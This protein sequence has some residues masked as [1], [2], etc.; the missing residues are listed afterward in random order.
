LGLGHY[1]SGPAVVA[2]DDTTVCVPDGFVGRI[3]ANAN[4]ILELRVQTNEEASA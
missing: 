4:L 2:Q 3:D 1:F